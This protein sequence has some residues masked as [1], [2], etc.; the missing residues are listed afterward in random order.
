MQIEK[1]SPLTVMVNGRAYPI[2][3]FP[4]DEIHI[5]FFERKRQVNKPL[6]YIGECRLKSVQPHKHTKLPFVHIC[7]RVFF[8][9]DEEGE[10]YMVG[11][12]DDQHEPPVGKIHGEFFGFT[13]IEF[14]KIDPKDFIEI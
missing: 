12:S 1:V 13:D 2:F 3:R 4:H 9:I 8:Y 14:M 10:L 11:Y 6:N 5:S 7:N